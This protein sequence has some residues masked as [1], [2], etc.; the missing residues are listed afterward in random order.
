[1][2]PINDPDIFRRSRPLVTYVLVALNVLVW[3]YQAYVISDLDEL[4]F[5]YQFGVIPAELLRDVE[6]GVE[7]LRS[8]GSI[9]SV[10]L[11]SPVPTWATVFTSMFLHG[12]FLHLAGNMVFL[13]V[14]GDNVEDRFGRARYLLFYLGAG[15]AAVWAQALIDPE[16]TTPMVGASGAIAGVLGAYFVLF[17]YSRINTL[18]FFGLVFHMRLAAVW[19]IGAWALLQ[20]FNGVGSLGVSSAGGGVAYF[21]HLGGF[22]AGLAV[23]GTYKV[24]RREPLFGRRR[25]A[26]PWR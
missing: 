18:F 7:R 20:A 19:L 10:D 17:P 2:I 3:L 5:T 11:T 16:S 9:V 6:L 1:M 21:A 15:A 8:G 25:P 23:A 13:W 4:I 12:G 14:F 24:I 22:A 26:P